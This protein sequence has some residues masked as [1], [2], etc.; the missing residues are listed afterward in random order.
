MKWIG[1]IFYIA[2][3][4]IVGFF[5]LRLS[6][7]NSQ[8]KYYNENAAEYLLEDDRENY[9]SR[10]MTANLID[11]Y[12]KE[13]VYLAQ[14]DETNS[15]E[16]EFAVYHLKVTGSEQES[17]YL[18]FYFNE[19]TFDY[20]NLLDDYEKYEEN[21]NLAAILIEVKMKDVDELT[22]NYYPLDVSLRMPVILLQQTLD[23]N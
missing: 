20:E 17:T 22:T 8:V 12:L 23:D 10:Y 4:L 2:L 11:T 16:F 6:Q 13:P 3:V 14:S 9:I 21:N 19:I 7:I 5:V 1:R 15:F 18:A